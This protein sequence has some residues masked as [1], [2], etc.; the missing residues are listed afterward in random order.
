[1][2][3]QW[4][5]QEVVE[6]QRLSRVIRAYLDSGGHLN[7]LNAQEAVSEIFDLCHNSQ[8]SFKRNQDEAG[9]SGIVDSLIQIVTA[10]H[11]SESLKLLS[12]RSLGQMCFGNESLSLMVGQNVELIKN[13]SMILSAPGISA[14]FKDEALYPLKN[15]AGN[16]WDTHPHLIPLVPQAAHTTHHISSTRTHVF[17]D[18]LHIT[19]CLALYITYCYQSRITHTT[20]SDLYSH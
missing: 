15:A 17:S 4:E 10:V 20:N 11:C 9:K 19:C 18:V 2:N 7:E 14:S 6:I 1:M 3:A 5:T 16:S 13:V 8:S 12:Y